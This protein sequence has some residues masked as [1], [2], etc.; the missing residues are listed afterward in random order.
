MAVTFGV[1]VA[2]LPLIDGCVYVSRAMLGQCP[3][4]QVNGGMPEPANSRG[5]QEREPS[6]P[7]AKRGAD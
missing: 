1:A 3:V 5:L 4:V 2:V 7:A 6:F